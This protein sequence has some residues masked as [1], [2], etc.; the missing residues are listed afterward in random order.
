MHDEPHLVGG[1][2]VCWCERCVNP[3]APLIWLSR[4]YHVSEQSTRVRTTTGTDGD[5]C[6]CT[7]HCNHTEEASDDRQ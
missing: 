2:C 3:D 6:I 1:Y 5:V 7:D 4:T